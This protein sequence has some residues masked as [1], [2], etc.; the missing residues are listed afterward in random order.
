MHLVIFH[1]EASK[2][3]SEAVL[4]YEIQK[5]GLGTR[6][7]MAVDILITKIQN[8]P[9]LFGYSKKPFREA[10]VPLFPYNIVFKINS[11]KKII[12]ISAVF[13]TNRNPKKKHRKI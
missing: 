1:P 7:A 6:F 3:F 8:N 10:S 12:Y 9:Q 11:K 13:N 5:R 4:W 2:E